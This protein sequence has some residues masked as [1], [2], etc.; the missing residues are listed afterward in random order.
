MNI[1]V[2]GITATAYVSQY[3][4]QPGD[5]CT[6][7]QG[8]VWCINR[9][10]KTN[11]YSWLR[12]RQSPDWRATPALKATC[13]GPCRIPN[14]G[15]PR[16][17]PAH[18]VAPADWAR[19]DQ[20]G[21]ALYKDRE[22]IRLSDVLK[23]P[24]LVAGLL[25]RTALGDP[26]G[27][28]AA[29]LVG[30]TDREADATVL[31]YVPLEPPTKAQ[32]QTVLSQFPGQPEAWLWTPPG[33]CRALEVGGSADAA[34]QASSYTRRP[35]GLA[36]LGAQGL[37]R[38]YTVARNFSA[39]YARVWGIPPREAMDR[40]LRNY[41]HIVALEW[42][43]VDPARL[44]P[45]VPHTLYQRALMFLGSRGLPP[46]E[47]LKR[48]ATAGVPAPERPQ[49]G[50]QPAPPQPAP[51][52]PAP[53]QP[54]PPQPAPPQPAPPQPAPPQPAP[55]Q[56]APPQ[57]GQLEPGQPEPGQQPGQQPGLPV[58]PAVPEWVGRL[59]HGTGGH[60]STGTYDMSHNHGILAN[61]SIIIINGGVYNPSPPPAVPH[62]PASGPPGSGAPG[63]G[64]PGAG[65]PGAGPPG[66]GP[67]GVRLPWSWWSRH[68]QALISEAG[69]A[70]VAAARL[71]RL[72]TEDR[73]AALRWLINA[74]GLTYQTGMSLE[75]FVAA[76]DTQ[77]ARDR[78][79]GG[80]RTRT[81][82]VGD[83]PGQAWAERVPYA[84]ATIATLMCLGHADR[85]TFVAGAA[86][87]P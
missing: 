37:D 19:V 12:G 60:V 47:Q 69:G 71:L 10:A 72:T 44:V 77:P 39:A 20:L 81:V 58:A 23:L 61:H 49:P 57:P 9:N 46:A 53:P 6:D 21:R 66:V 14:H 8:V 43:R 31:L 62:P 17:S 86:G 50:S 59:L 38:V 76:A 2:H 84:L 3:D 1:R 73:D 11:N 32:A 18:A 5:S 4:G 45:V 34:G 83:V 16:A 82:Q 74:R 54:A 78:F 24:V 28:P 22:V 68:S 13:H 52:Q 7:D 29:H 75:E 27:S 79:N 35:G 30:A 64:A 63:A 48:L 87:Q 25:V 40:W 65:P 67:P 33:K 70:A 15:S 36:G 41:N 42:V 85:E 55:P 80:P 51:P 26:Q 56:P